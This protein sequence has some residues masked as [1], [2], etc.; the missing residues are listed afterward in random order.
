LSTQVVTI[1]DMSATT[2]PR[3]RNPRGEG[4][5]LRAALID[6]CGELL[7]E[8]GTSEGLSIRAVTSRAGVSP[9]ALYLHFADLDELLAA[10]C[11]EAFEELVAY[12]VGAAAGSDGDPRDELRAMGR[13]YVD[14]AEQRPGL[15][16]ILFATPARGVTSPQEGSDPGMDAFAALVVATERCVGKGAHAAE[17]AVQLWTALHGFVTLRTVLPADKPG[18][19]AFPTADE[20]LDRLFAAYVAPPARRGKSV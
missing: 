8:R 10:V 17:I 1:F 3:K 15:Y 6:A 7:L 12:L 16:R 14:F 13:A 4:E 18:L 20:F 9:T 11:D 2:R 19:P 5:R